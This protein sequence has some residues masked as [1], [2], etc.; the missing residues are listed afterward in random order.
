M[1][2]ENPF[3]LGLL[4]NLF[5]IIN[6]KQWYKDIF[7]ENPDIVFLYDNLPNCK[8]DLLSNLFTVIYVKQC[9]KENYL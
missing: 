4:S 9:Y 5:T 2:L 1:V 6:V 7:L 3:N 8:L